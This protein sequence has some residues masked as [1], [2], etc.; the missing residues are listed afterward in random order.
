TPDSS[1]APDA[2]TP[3]TSVVRLVALG[4]TGEGNE[5]QRLVAEQMGKHCM[6]VGGC[7]AVVMLGDNFYDNG[8][9]SVDDPQWRTKFEDIYDVPG[10]NGLKFY[11]ALGNHDYG[12]TSSGSRDAQLDYSQ[13]PVGKD[14][15]QRSSDKWVM[16]MPYY[17]VRLG[18]VHL[19]ALDNQDYGSA[20]R[21]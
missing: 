6:A 12:Y 13:L 16:P 1:T 5:A 3:S 10:L 11:V 9:V 14:A 20:Q 7:T 15:G 17:D 18:L 21:E 19:F 8:V 4:D 2:S